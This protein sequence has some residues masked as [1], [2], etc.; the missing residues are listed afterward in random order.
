MGDF[1]V[2]EIEVFFFTGEDLLLYLV[3]IEALD[4]LVENHLIAVVVLV[5]AGVAGA[6]H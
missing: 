1:N 4:Q 6:G 3:V 2:V 5:V